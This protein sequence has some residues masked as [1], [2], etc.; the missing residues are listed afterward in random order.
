MCDDIELTVG[1][2]Q[3]LVF[4]AGYVGYK[5]VR[6]LSCDLCRDELVCDKTLQFDASSAD[7]T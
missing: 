3:S 4:I 5:A 2:T 1:E 7:S 6:K